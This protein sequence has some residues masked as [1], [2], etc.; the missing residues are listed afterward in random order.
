MALR[1]SHACGLSLHCGPPPE[2]RKRSMATR[3]LL[4]LRFRCIVQLVRHHRQRY[5]LVQKSEKNTKIKDT[6]EK[7]QVCL[8]YLQA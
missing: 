7:L 6:R 4:A 3:D 2:S 1:E 8:G 5:S